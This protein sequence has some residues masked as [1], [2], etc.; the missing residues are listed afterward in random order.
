MTNLYGQ[1]NVFVYSDDVEGVDVTQVTRATEADIEHSGDE[2]IDNT[3]ISS[4]KVYKSLREAIVESGYF[5]PMLEFD[6]N[7]SGREKAATIAIVNE[8]L[9][10]E[11]YLS[12]YGPAAVDPWK[13]RTFTAEDMKY[14]KPA[15]PEPIETVEIPDEGGDHGDDLEPGLD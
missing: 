3:I 4:S 14:V 2:Y 6:K 8:L 1:Y 9:K 12:G 5:A 7:F 15:I 11:E 13:G 10:D